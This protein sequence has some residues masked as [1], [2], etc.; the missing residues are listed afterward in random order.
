MYL[1]NKFIANEQA[2]LA[3]GGQIL[4]NLSVPRSV[5]STWEAVKKWR[6]QNDLEAPL[7]F[8]WFSLALDGLFTIGAV[9]FFG[10]L[11]ERTRSA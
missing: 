9:D 1:P 10:D 11:I 4:L 6:L 3:I 8:W 5:S 7:P 2:L